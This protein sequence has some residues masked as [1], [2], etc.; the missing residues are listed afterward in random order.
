[1]A[2]L[3]PL[4]LTVSCF[5]KIQIGLP[6][7]YRLTRVVPEKGPLNRCVKDLS[8]ESKSEWVGD[9][10]P[11]I[12]RGKVLSWE[13][14]SPRKRNSRPP[15]SVILCWVSWVENVLLIYYASVCLHLKK[16]HRFTAFLDSK[17][18]T[19]L[20]IVTANEPG[21]SFSP[22]NLPKNIVQIRPRFYLV[23]VVTN[24]RTD[25]QTDRQTNARR[26]FHNPSRKLSRG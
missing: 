5:S 3:M 13:Y 22:R 20:A 4:P 10:I 15:T 25:R 6:F 7:W 19:R 17:I 12:T 2:Q 24:E 1:M 21:P 18:H 23:I 11:I 8:L 9:G 26:W 16:N 14:R